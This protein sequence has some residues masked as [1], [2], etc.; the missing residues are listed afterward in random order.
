MISATFETALRD[1]RKAVSMYSDTTT[2]NGE[3]TMKTKTTAK[4]E[5]A[6]TAAKTKTTAKTE[7]AKTAAKTKTAKPKA[8]GSGSHP[9]LSAS[10]AEPM[11]CATCGKAPS[12]KL[13][14]RY[15]DTARRMWRDGSLEERKH[16]L[17]HLTDGGNPDEAK[18][19]WT[20][21]PAYTKRS[22]AACLD[23][24]AEAAN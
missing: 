8:N 13:H 20:A 7:P 16:Y 19:T 11:K 22:L 3:K 18:L 5:P 21:L 14:R 15:M 10:E 1:I 2:T 12:G 24:E 6:K 4:T 17:G 23:L 9:F